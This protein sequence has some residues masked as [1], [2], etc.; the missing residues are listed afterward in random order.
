MFFIM[1]GIHLISCV[2]FIAG[3]YNIDY[4]NFNPSTTKS[5]MIDFGMYQFDA[6]G[7]IVFQAL[8]ETM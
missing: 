2:F 8:P 7:N 5:W 4:S 6:D 1:L 3:S